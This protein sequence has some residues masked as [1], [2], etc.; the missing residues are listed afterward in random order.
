M[1]KSN[2]TARKNDLEQ[3]LEYRGSSVLQKKESEAHKY[4]QLF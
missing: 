3:F 2:S 4:K 1:T